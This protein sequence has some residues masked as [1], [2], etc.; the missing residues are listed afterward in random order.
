MT[1]KGTFYFGLHSPKDHDRLA[2]LLAQLEGLG[3]S[4][5]LDTMLNPGTNFQ[6]VIQSALNE[7]AGLVVFVSQHSLHTPAIVEQLDILRQVRQDDILQVVLDADLSPPLAGARVV[8]DQADQAAPQIAAA[9]AGMAGEQAPNHCFSEAQA[10]Q[11]ADLLAARSQIKRPQSSGHTSIF[12]VHGHDHALRDEVEGYLSEQ[13]IHAVI[14]S[15]AAN[16]S[17]SLFQKFLR[18]SEDADFAVVLLSADDYGASR[19]QYD[20][21]GVADRALQFRARQNVILELGFFYG[22]L[23]WEHVFVLFKPAAEVFPNFE[24]PSDLGGI[25]FDEVDAAGAWK[26]KLAK[27]LKEAGFLMA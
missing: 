18:F 8:I 3:V 10:A 27:R 5:W 13:G 21:T 11:F 23:G 14:L 6:Q 15:E 19:R 4:I 26:D 2:P 12:I 17:E 22:F 20:A 9:L 24:I 25:L 16:T 1:T 7:A